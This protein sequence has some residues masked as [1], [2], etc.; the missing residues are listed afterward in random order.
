MFLI[1]HNYKKVK[2]NLKR[3][4]LTNPILCIFHACSTSVPIRQHWA[5]WLAGLTETC[6]KLPSRK[7]CK[8]SKGKRKV[9]DPQ[10]EKTHGFNMYLFCGR[11]Y[12]KYK[13]IWNDI[14]KGIQ[15]LMKQ[16]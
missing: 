3:L 13:I 8:L 7:C 6:S 2:L 10:I 14:L 11:L 15:N 1:Y 4:S 12:L 16:T 9:K 5:F